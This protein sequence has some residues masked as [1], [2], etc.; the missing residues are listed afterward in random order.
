MQRVEL[1]DTTLRD[2]SQ[3]EGVSYSAADKIRIA[4]KLDSLGMHYIEGG[5]PVSNPKDLEFFK[6]IKRQG[7]KNSEVIAFGSTRR[8]KVKASNDINI[9][10]LLKAKVKTVCI[11]GKTW[12]LHVKDVLRTSLDE[13]LEMIEDSV[14]Y[15]KSKG[16]N[17][18]YDAEHFFDGYKANPVYALNT[19]WA[20][21][22]GGCKTIV[23]CDT[24][25]GTITSD[26][27]DIIETINHKVNVKLGIHT[28]NDNEMAVANSVAAY[29]AGCRHIQGT[30]NGYGERCGNANLISIIPILKLKLGVNCIPDK[31]LKELTEV[32]RFVAEVVNMKHMD[33]Q[34]F[35]GQS[36]FAH[37]GGVH[38]NAVM[39]NIKSYEHVKP[40]LVGNKRRFLISELSG[41]TSILIKAKELE[42]DLRKNTPQAKKILSLLQKLEHQGY[43]FEAAEESFELLMKRALKKYKNFFQLQGFKVLVEKKKDKLI[44]EATIKLKVKGKI[45]HTAAEGDGPVNALDNALRKALVDFYPTLSQMHLSDFRVRVLDEKTGTAAK[46]RVLIESQ[47]AKD[48]WWTIG[49]SE[50]IIEASWQALQDSVEYKLLK[51]K[52]K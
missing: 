32:S 28:H 21:C 5:W 24:N 1:Y 17:V 40:E 42:L 50:N 2:G 36:A 48:S 7:L 15:L 8:A 43:H 44:S 29:L 12:D 14:R 45:E 41:K 47:D 6:Q 37:K 31:K 26:I 35:T 30:I 3:G 10:A 51:D 19:L 34:P 11:F 16:L 39:K 4:K 13:N 27:T 49:V 9:K 22:E 20:A 46:V 52:T 38:I 33:N 25:G 18:I 23:L